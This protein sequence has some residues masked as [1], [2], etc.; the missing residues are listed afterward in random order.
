M[1]PSS[2]PENQRSAAPDLGDEVA[3]YGPDLFGTVFVLSLGLAMLVGSPVLGVYFLQLKGHWGYFFGFLIPALLMG[4]PFT[5]FGTK[6]LRTQCILYRDGLTYRRYWSTEAIRFDS[7]EAVGLF[8]GSRGAAQ[9]CITTSDGSQHW[10]N[11]LGN[12]DDAALRIAHAANVRVH[13]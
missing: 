7:I 13:F 10:F 9:M 11:N 3:R 1:I 6:M 5:Y 2:S 12:I 4:V 8:V